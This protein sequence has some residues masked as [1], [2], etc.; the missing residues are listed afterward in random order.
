M[1]GVRTVWTGTCRNTELSNSEEGFVLGRSGH[2][3]RA[4]FF[5]FTCGGF[6]VADVRIRGEH[7]TKLLAELFHLLQRGLLVLVAM[8]DPHL[9]YASPYF[10]FLHPSA[11][12]ERFLAA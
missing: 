1:Y 8:H 6:V 12:F 9:P 11:L 3:T 4:L 7:E 5:C 2:Q 10:P